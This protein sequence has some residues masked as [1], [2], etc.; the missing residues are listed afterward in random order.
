M[1][2]NEL[3]DDYDSSCDGKDA[4]ARRRVDL[5][6]Q[7]V[8]DALEEEGH[9]D[10][11]ELHVD[12]VSLQS[13]P[14]Q[15]KGGRTFPPTS[16]PRASRTRVFVPQ[17]FLGHTL[18]KS[19]LT[20]SQSR[21]VCSLSLTSSALPTSVACPLSSL[22]C[23]AS[24]WWPSG[25]ECACVALSAASESSCSRSCGEVGVVCGWRDWGLEGEGSS[26]RSRA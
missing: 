3:T 26:G 2:E 6:I 22:R 15:R 16:S 1:Q 21:L 4:L 14:Q 5:D 23:A 7:R 19:F 10:V 18:G 20:M 25:P 12:S 9:L 17:S 24:F 11:E 8:D 13:F